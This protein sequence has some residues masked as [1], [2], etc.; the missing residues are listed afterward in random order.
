MEGLPSGDIQ[1]KY[2]KLAA[3]YSK[4]CISIISDAVND[5][6]FG[7]FIV[8][9]VAVTGA[10]E[11]AKKGSSRRAGEVERTARYVERQGEIFEERR[12]GDRFVNIQKP[13]V[14]AARVCPPG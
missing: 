3:E 11:G 5:R 1:A 7:E 4:V 10:C 13:A 9:V 14:D 6:Q 12:I 8:S 2:Q